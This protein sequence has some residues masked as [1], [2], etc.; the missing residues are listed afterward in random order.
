MANICCDDVYFFSKT[1]P[2]G[3]RSLWEDL[4]TS[5][6]LC[7]DI[8]KAW[9]GNLFQYKKIDTEDIS[10]CGTVGYMEWNGDNIL[11]GLET[12]WSPL[13][14]A[15]AAIAKAY[16]VTFV[17]QS[18]EP[19]ESIYFNTDHS[20]IYFPDHYIISLE[21][22]DSLTPSGIRIGDKLEYGQM[23]ESEDSLLMYFHNLGY[24]AKS[25]KELKGVLE[26]SDIY[27]HEFEDPYES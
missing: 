27:I 9:L 5:I 7:R 1:N 23:F 3:I 24:H 14:D 12:R 20:G 26:G 4:E 13:F 16:G 19:G 6:I 17:M 18:I 2:E 8:E 22:E 15:Y 21:D 11:L 10:L 25:V